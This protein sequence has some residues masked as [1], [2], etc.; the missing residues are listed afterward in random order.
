MTETSTTDGDNPNNGDAGTDSTAS[1]EPTSTST[2]NQPAGD[3]D[4]LDD[5]SKSDDS[6]ST[7]D[8]QKS[9]DDTKTDD[10]APASTELDS[11]LEDWI[12]GR[13]LAVPD[14][15]E[16]KQ[17]L[18]DLRNEQRDFT[19]ARQA[20]KATKDAKALGDEV[21][22]SK[23]E[24][25]DDDDD[26]LDPLEK[27]VKANEEL[28]QQER[29]TRLQSEFYSTNSVTPEQHKAILDIYKEKVSTP[30]TPEG[31]QKAFDLWSSP[32]ALPDLLDLAKA[33]LGKGD[34][35]GA[36][37]DEAARKERERIARES[38]ATSPGRGAKTSTSGDKTEDQK[39][40]ERFSNWD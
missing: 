17:A 11:D 10:K 13:G 24:T 32:D 20:E 33:R 37:A 4:N 38:Q 14:T 39:R 29:T 12:K 19:K 30:T 2:D 21:H 34:D 9:A 25:T 31:K 8:D 26:E 22:K 40:L 16:G 36:V 35:S 3:S 23:P 15:D 6:K 5:S 28:Y 18:Q 7:D 1:T 27:R